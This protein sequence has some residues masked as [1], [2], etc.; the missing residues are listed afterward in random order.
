M[1]DD[2]PDHITDL[3]GEPQYPVTANFPV[4]LGYSFNTCNICGSM[5]AKGK[6]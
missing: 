6:R 1:S 2:L 5:N 3:I 4:E